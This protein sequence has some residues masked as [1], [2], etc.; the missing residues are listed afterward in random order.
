M[1]GWRTDDAPIELCVIWLP[2]ALS[3]KMNPDLSAGNCA[4]TYST[5]SVCFGVS[6]SAIVVVFVSFF[7]NTRVGWRLVEGGGWWWVG[8]ELEACTPEV[9]F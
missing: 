7:I 3:A 1:D 4:R 5:S 8:L 9:E 6:V 2:P